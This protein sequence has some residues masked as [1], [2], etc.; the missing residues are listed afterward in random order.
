M[1]YWY[2]LGPAP[3]SKPQ[4]AKHYAGA[5]RAFTKYAPSIP[6]VL[7]GAGAAS[8]TYTGNPIQGAWLAKKA[9]DTYKYGLDSAARQRRFEYHRYGTIL[10]SRY[11][12]YRK[13]KYGQRY[14][15]TQ[16]WV[17][18]HIW[19]RR[20][21]IRRKNKYA[22]YKRHPEKGFTRRLY[23]SRFRYTDPNPF[24]P[25]RYYRRFTTWN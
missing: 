21:R 12:Q 5:K 8:S 9:Y 22:Y 20:K 16:R 10:P 24:N 11:Y 1:S 14:G 17:P 4:V 6:A 18:Y 3:G 15:R 7:F 13:Y 23:K 25:R 19:A 2:N